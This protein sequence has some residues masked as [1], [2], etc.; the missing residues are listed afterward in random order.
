LLTHTL[1]RSLTRRVG[2]GRPIRRVR[3]IP[4][5]VVAAGVSPAKTGNAT[6]GVAAPPQACIAMT[7][8]S[9]TMFNRG[10]HR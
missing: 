10:Y 4:M 8:G 7:L 3:A 1:A 6:T 2:G 5:K 9:E